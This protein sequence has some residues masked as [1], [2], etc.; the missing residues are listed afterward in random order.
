M[1]CQVSRGVIETPIGPYDVS[2]CDSGLHSVQLSSDVTDDNFLDKGESEISLQGLAKNQI[3]KQLEL[4]M[5]E[6]FSNERK[7]CFPDISI[8]REVVDENNSNVFSNQVL[9]SLK[10]EVGFGETISYGELAKKA[11]KTSGAARAVGT[12]MA[13]NKIGLV[14]PC[15]RVI[16][17]DGSEGNYAKAT[18]NSVKKWLLQH[19]K[20]EN[21]K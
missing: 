8:C 16:K 18:K 1:A 13:N 11:G 17:S 9:S 7:K 14:I 19:E 2:A 12:V 4:W 21:G 15:H 5:R 6:Y 20:L 3:L 10:R